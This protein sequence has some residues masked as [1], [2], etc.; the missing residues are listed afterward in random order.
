MKSKWRMKNKM[1]KY[2]KVLMLI[3]L[4]VVT[5]SGC[6]NIDGPFASVIMIG[7]NHANSGDYNI[8]EFVFTETNKSNK[9]S[10]EAFLSDNYRINKICGIIV[11]ENPMCFYDEIINSTIENERWDTVQ[12]D[13]NDFAKSIFETSADDEEVDT[14]EAFHTAMNVFDSVKGNVEK[15]IIIFDSGL[16]TAGALDFA[17]DPYYNKLI[18][19]DSDLTNEEIQSILDELIKSKEIPD[20]SDVMIQWYGIGIVGDK[21]P[22]LSK[23]NISNLKAIWNAILKN[24][25]VRSVEFIDVTKTKPTQPD[26]DLPNVSVVDLDEAI[27]RL[28]PEMLGF[29][30]GTDEFM[31]GT[32]ENRFKILSRFSQFG[33]NNKLL[34]VGTTSTGGGNGDGLQLSADRADA[35]KTELIAIGVPKENIDTM[36]LGPKSHKYNP[37]EYVDGVYQ[38]ESIAAK[39]N[40]SVYIMSANCSEAI[41]FQDDYNKI[42]T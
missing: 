10:N 15:R 13:V 23:L 21:Q 27:I 31:E 3:F 34:I 1:K 22:E 19:K 6:K 11:D 35:V 4:F 41:V 42:Y 36:G 25:G 12:S 24:A 40:R 30:P 14:L 20:L 2:V 28:D 38:G 8:P 9:S 39:E 33:N 17:N 29:K 18:G 32:E 7:G 37:D 26:K 5:L 16:S